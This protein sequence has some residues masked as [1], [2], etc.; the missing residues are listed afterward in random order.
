MLVT[1]AVAVRAGV[2]GI[3]DVVWG[4]GFLPMQAAQYVPGWP[5]AFAWAGT[6]LWA[7]GIGF[8]AVGGAQ[9]ARFRADPANRART[10]DRGLWAGTQH[11]NC[12]GDFCLWWGPF[13]LACD[14]PAAAVVSPAV[15][16]VLLT[17]RSGKRLLEQHTADR[18]GYA[19]YRA[20]TS[21]FFPRPPRGTRSGQRG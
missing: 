8:E 13:V 21:G 10:M 1:F 12:F 15:M 16:A 4:I 2:H 14:S 20:R 19:G 11:P 3:V 7:V 9:L 18:P 6:A 17:E 5:C